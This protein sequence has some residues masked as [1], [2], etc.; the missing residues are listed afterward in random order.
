[1]SNELLIKRLKE[2]GKSSYKTDNAV[3]TKSA[4]DLFSSLNEGALSSPMI[5]SLDNVFKKKIKALEEAAVRSD[6]TNIRVALLGN[7]TLEMLASAVRVV[8]LTKGFFAEVYECAYGLME[9]EII[10]ANSAFYAF[11]PDV[12]LIAAGY[13]DI[14]EF[15]QPHT[16]LAGVQKLAA[17][18]ADIYKIFWDMISSRTPCH[19]VQSNFD[20]P[21]ERPF[22]ELEA[23]YPWAATNFIRRLNLKLGETA[24][25]NVSILDA[26]HLSSRLGKTCWFDERFY[27][28]SK[29]AFSFDCV[30]EY[31]S[32]FAAIVS[33]IKG[34]SKKCLVL[35]LDN[36]LWGGTVGDDGIENIVFGGG[37]AEGEAYL[38]FARYINKLKKRGVILAVSSKNYAD[39]A[40][41]PFLKMSQMPLKLDDFAAFKANWND[42]ASNIKTIAKELNIGLDSIVF[43][44]NDPVERKLIK[45][46]L[47]MVTVVELLDDPSLHKR[48]LYQGHYF[49]SI[50]ISKEDGKRSEH[51][52][53]KKTFDQEKNKFT[54][55]DSFLA[56]LDMEGTI[57]IFKQEDILRITQLIN[58]TNQFNLTTK[59]Y[60]ESDVKNFMEDKDCLAL[61]ARLKDR[62]TDYGLISVFLGSIKGPVLTVDTWLMSCRV[63]S[64]GMERF[65]FSHVVEI[66]KR[67]G[68]SRIKGLYIPSKKNRIVEDLYKSLGF[69]LTETRPG[70][71]T[72]W[73]LELEGSYPFIKTHVKQEAVSR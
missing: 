60:T 62:F 20:V 72:E 44:D 17:E 59:R 25:D 24:P 42:K 66:C 33:A 39:T 51:Y 18:Y 11:K 58:K 45:E 56:S 73:K 32:L 12:V 16:E 37:S 1:L 8:L 68:I 35:D 69:S 2:W 29:H 26:E 67:R 40:K 52:H 46:M 19:I 10:D 47:P 70:G 13:R 54:D 38:E 23:K 21:I 34:K 14:K 48:V 5:K 53:A 36:T 49:E 71:V 50:G 65:L 3:N 15:P 27:H 57:S 30:P 41:E 61:S 43:A 64:R 28:H 9:Q 6:I 63:F 22:G 55:I 31:A 7:S 4:I